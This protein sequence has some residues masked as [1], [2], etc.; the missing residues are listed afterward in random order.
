MLTV[1][2]DLPATQIA[3]ECLLVVQLLKREL[4]TSELYRTS[5]APYSK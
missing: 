2:P 4:L 5:I 3:P 1:L